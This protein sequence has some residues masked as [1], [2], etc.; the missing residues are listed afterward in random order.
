[1]DDLLDVAA[2]GAALCTATIWPSTRTR[3]A[4]G[5][6]LLNLLVLGAEEDRLETAR[7]KQAVSAIYQNVYACAPDDPR[8]AAMFAGLEG[9]L[10]LV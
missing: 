2:A 9:S 1:M 5:V 8:L 10:E 6:G 7:L 4:A 3:I